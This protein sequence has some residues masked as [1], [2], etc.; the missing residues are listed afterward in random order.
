MKVQRQLPET[1][2]EKGA[3]KNITKFTGRHLCHS[4]FLNKVAGLF[5]RVETLVNKAPP[6]EAYV[7][8]CQTSKVEFYENSLRRKVIL[9]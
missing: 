5:L 3:L 9:I 7:K 8:C 1:F 6:A 4:L 2:C